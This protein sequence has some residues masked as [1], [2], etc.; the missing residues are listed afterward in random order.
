MFFFFDYFSFERFNLIT[1][2]DWSMYLYF[3]ASEIQDR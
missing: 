3:L 2:N 1:A